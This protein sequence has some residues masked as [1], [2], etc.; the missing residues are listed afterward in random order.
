MTKD[1]SEVL[2]GTLDL[3]VPETLDALGPRRDGIARRIE[4]LSDELLRLNEGTVYASLLRLVQKGWI[5]SEWAPDS[6]RKAKFYSITRLAATTRPRDRELGTHL[7]CD[8]PVAAGKAAVARCCGAA[9]TNWGR[10]KTA[11]TRVR[12]RSPRTPGHAPERF[13]RRGW[14]R[15]RPLRGAATVGRVTQVKEGASGALCRSSRAGQEVRH[16]VRRLRTSRRF[17]ASAVLT[18][19]LG[20]GATTAVFA[21]L[22]TVLQPLPTS[23][24]TG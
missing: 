18:L 14:S 19:A 4:Q 15:P 1:R 24:R 13:I 7:R 5:R 17:T 22:N 20:I 6:N 8:R 21:V 9:L 3:M 16:A 12:R 11:A 23:N 10:S 2:Q